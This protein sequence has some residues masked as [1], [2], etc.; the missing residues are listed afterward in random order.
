MGRHKI[1]EEDKVVNMVVSIR[2]Y[3]LD[4]I[5]NDPSALSEIRDFIE[6]RWGIKDV[7]KYDE[8]DG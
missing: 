8:K 7:E 5:N 4:N 1:N 3:I 2:G 6:D